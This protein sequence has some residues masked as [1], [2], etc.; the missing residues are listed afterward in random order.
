M[1]A[2]PPIDLVAVQSLRCFMERLPDENEGNEFETTKTASSEPL[3]MIAPEATKILEI[4]RPYEG[5]CLVLDVET[6]TDASQSLRVGMYAV[7]G[8]SEDRRIELCRLGRLDRTALDGVAE[9]GVFYDPREVTTKEIKLIEAFAK[10][11]RWKCFTRIE[12][13]EKIFYHWVY[14][15]QALCIGHNLPFDLSRLATKWGAGTKRFYNGFWLSLCDCEHGDKCFY[16]PPLRIKMLGSKKASIK[17]RAVKPPKGR[18]PIGP[19]RFLDTSTFGLALLGDGDPSLEGLGKTFNA[20]VR[21]QSWPEEHGG[22]ITADYLNYNA[23]D[24]DATWA[25]HQEERKLYR[26]HNLATPPWKIFS[27]AS[28][29]KAY[30]KEM[31]VPRFMKQHLDFPDPVLGYVMQGFYGGRAEVRI[32]LQPTE[33]IHTDFRSQYPSVNALMGNQTLLLAETIEAK[34]C[35]EEIQSFLESLTLDDLQRPATWKRL[36]GVVKI[37]PNAD[38]LPVRTNYTEKADTL[39][40]GVNYVTSPIPVWYLLPDIVASWLITGRWPEILDAIDLVPRGQVATTPKALFDDPNYR[41]DLTRDDFFTRVIDFRMAIRASMTTPELRQHDRDYLD[42]LQLALKLLANS[43]SYGIL[44]EVNPTRDSH[45]KQKVTVH[46]GDA[47]RINTH[48]VE[49]PGDYYAAPV[50]AGI[51]AGARLLVMLAER[52]AEDRGMGYVFC[53]TDSMAFARPANMPRESFERRV[54]E[55]IDWFEPLSPYASKGSLLQREAVNDWRGK[56]EPLFC[57]AVSAKRY[58]LYNKLDDGTFRIRKFSAHGTGDL[59]NPPNYEPT[60]PEPCGNVFKLGGSRWKYDSWYWAIE[61]IEAGETDIIIDRPELEIPVLS[62]L[63]L[64]TWHRFND[65]KNIPDITPFTFCTVLPGLSESEIVLRWNLHQAHKI[66]VGDSSTS[67]PYEGLKGVT[68]YAPFGKSIDDV[69]GNI[70]R[71]DNHELINIKHRTLKER[72]RGYC[73]HAEAKSEP[74][75]GVGLLAR[76]H[77]YVAEHTFIGK[78]SNQVRDDTAEETGNIVAA[79]APQNYVR[80]GLGEVIKSIGVRK[81]AKLTGIARQTLYDIIGGTDPT[82]EIRR[83]LIEA[84]KNNPKS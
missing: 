17:F 56:P 74:G 68:F 4:G 50:G 21:K 59:I 41:I 78:E 81:L 22:P 39:N 5:Y 49:A 83:L 24:I 26:Q 1:N 34:H 20:A 45:A 77:V 40:I 33:V 32:R 3:V 65:Y 62:K 38:I 6:T 70:K 79:E 11:R 9:R 72:L 25:L 48:V 82:Q 37:K 57:M 31:G 28:L 47:H 10:G 12:F 36:R 73:R 71:K 51:A 75:N 54:Q 52:L 15:R 29:G 13:I 30:L 66:E 16:H 63:T 53:D 14:W 69:R 35:A 84:V 43:T 18:P 19:G 2:T 55:I 27:Q 42:G 61:K 67:N 64:T 8:I 44:V 58:A 23:Q 60:T 7:Y 46:A 76:R 80:E